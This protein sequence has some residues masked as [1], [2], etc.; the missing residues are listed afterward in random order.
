M[1]KTVRFLAVAASLL[2]LGACQTSSLSPSAVNKIQAAGYEQVT[3]VPVNV[4]STTGVAAYLCAP[5]KCGNLRVIVVNSV[6][7]N[8]NSAGENL[9]TQVRKAGGNPAKVQSEF[10][11]GFTSTSPTRKISSIRFYTART[12]AGIYAYGT[13]VTPRGNRVHFAGRVTFR[14]N[15]AGAT[16]GLSDTPASARSALNL[17]LED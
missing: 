17:A 1:F 16:L 6:N 4:G 7:G 2:V 13:D 5:A 15:T 11:R 10:A 9:E 8:S 12:H 3:S 14:G